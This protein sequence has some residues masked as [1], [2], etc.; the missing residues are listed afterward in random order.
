MMFNTVNENL[1]ISYLTLRKLIGILGMLLPF[2][3]LFGGSIFLGRPVLD[4][5][6]AYYHSNMRDVL[7]GLLVGVSL[8]LMAYKGYKGYDTWLAI[9]SGVAG[10]GIALFPCASR[11]DPSTPVGIL[12][13]TPPLATVLH[14]GSSVLFFILLAVYSFFVFT[15]GDK[16]NWTKSKTKR[17]IIY[18]TCAIIIMASLATLLILLLTLGGEGIEATI[19]TFIFE[20]VML[21]AFGF[22]WW[23]KGE[24]LFKDKKDEPRFAK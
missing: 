8:F 10:L 14:F 2:V 20:T 24:T 9:L 3:C 17:N 19:W 15:I 21:W 13:L 6:S 7:T 22:S 4:S 16:Q 23:V 11:I 5:I 12:Q 18:R 1:I